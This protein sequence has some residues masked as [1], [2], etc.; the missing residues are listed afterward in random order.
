MAIDISAS[1]RLVLIVIGGLAILAIYIAA[2]MAQNKSPAA[3]ARDKSSAAAGLKR[4]F[5]L[6]QHKLAFFARRG[7]NRPQLAQR[8]IPKIS[9]ASTNESAAPAP[10]S[11]PS[12][13]LVILY[14]QAMAGHPFS[15]PAIVHAAKR[16][17]LHK[18]GD[19]HQGFFQYRPPGHSTVVHI[20]NRVKPGFFIWQEMDKLS[21]TGLSVFAEL[22]AADANATLMAMLDSAHK[23]ADTLGGRLL[24]ENH[25]ALT[26]TKIKSIQQ[27]LKSFFSARHAKN[28]V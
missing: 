7:N 11:P 17:G 10:A 3:M 27:E 19:Q 26:T 4:W 13:Y 18:T 2:L 16:I 21:T 1:L 22:Q 9:S 14:V 20:T 15:G 12:H 24:D 23:L 28:S 25:H 8:V 5:F 6:L